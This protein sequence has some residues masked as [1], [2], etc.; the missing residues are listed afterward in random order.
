MTAKV[1]KLP[2]PPRGGTDAAQFKPEEAVWREAQANLAKEYAKNVKDW[3]MLKDAVKQ[4]IEDQ[5]KLVAWW[6]ET[7]TPRLSNVGGKANADPGS[8]SKREAEKLPA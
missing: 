5:R 7:V 8:L 1:H 4:Q 6:T 2:V 3:E